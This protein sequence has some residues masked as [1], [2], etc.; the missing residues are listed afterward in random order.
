M[1]GSGFHIH[2]K[3]LGEAK[4]LVLMEQ[5]KEQNVLRTNKFLM[6]LLLESFSVVDVVTRDNLRETYI[7]RNGWKDFF[8]CNFSGTYTTALFVTKLELVSC[9]GIAQAIFS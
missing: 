7:K 5:Y 8:C 9:L 2:N 6:L 1:E 4:E 3:L